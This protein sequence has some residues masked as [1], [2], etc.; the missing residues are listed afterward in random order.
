MGSIPGLTRLW[1]LFGF[2]QG[3]AQTE[4]GKEEGTEAQADTPFSSREVLHHSTPPPRQL[5]PEPQLPSGST[6]SLCPWPRGGHSSHCC[7]P[8]G[9]TCPCWFP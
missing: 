6:L 1:L 2:G 5:L 3:E 7:E 4:H 9:P 8:W